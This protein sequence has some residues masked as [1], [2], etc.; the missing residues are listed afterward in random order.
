MMDVSAADDDVAERPDVMRDGEDEQACGEERHE[1]GDGGQQH[2]P[3]R[4]VGNSLMENAADLGEVQ[5]DEDSCRHQKDEEEQN[6]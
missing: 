5:E 1:E 4:P 6:P 2:A 3:M